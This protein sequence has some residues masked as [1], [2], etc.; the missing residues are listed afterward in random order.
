MIVALLSAL[1]CLVSP[2]FAGTVDL[3]TATAEELDDL[4]GV[5]PKIAEAILAYRKAHGRFGSVD[6]LYDVKGIGDAT[7]AKLR[8]L[9]SVGA[10]GAAPATAGTAD[11]APPP[12]KGRKAG[13]EPVPAAAPAAA[14]KGRATAAEAS[15]G[16]AAPAAASGSG[17]PVNIN[18]ADAAWL[19]DLPGVGE[20]KAAALLASRQEA[21]PFPSCAD[22]SRVPGFGAATIGKLSACCVVK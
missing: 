17:C 12:G 22:L 11:A 14:A 3:N 4:P 6:E 8:P 13:K 9:V 1:L 10:A 5:G 19:M 15:A 7:M 18:T 20:G 21:G 2:S 16:T